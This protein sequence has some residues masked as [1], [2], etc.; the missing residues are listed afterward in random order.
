MLAIALDRPGGPQA[1]FWRSS[2]SGARDGA[3]GQHKFYVTGQDLGTDEVNV[4]YDPQAEVNAYLPGRTFDLSGT[5]QPLPVLRG[6]PVP[7][8]HA[9]M[10]A[11][12]P[13]R[14]TDDFGLGD[15]GGIRERQFLNKPKPLLPLHSLSK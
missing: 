7:T 9:C 5:G 14:F 1:W 12:W 2:P 13:G 11:S 10:L 4:Y 6:Q 3:D 15:V 8:M